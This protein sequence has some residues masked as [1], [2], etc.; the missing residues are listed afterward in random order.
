MFGI[1]SCVCVCA[2]ARARILCIRVMQLVFGRYNKCVRKKGLCF[3]GGSHSS[4]ISLSG[5]R[6]MRSTLAATPVH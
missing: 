5:S 2:R 3:G 6:R 1:L 4:E